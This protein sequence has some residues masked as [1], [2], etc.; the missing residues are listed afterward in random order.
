MVLYLEIKKIS[1]V[2]QIFENIKE[3][4]QSNVYKPGDKLPSEIVLAE[5]YGVSRVSVRTAIQRLAM[6]GMIDIRV[7]EGSFV[8]EFNFRDLTN[9]I[10][11]I[12]A[13]NSMLEFLFE[14]RSNIEIHCVKLAISRAADYELKQLI[15]IARDMFEKAKN[16]D[17]SGY[18]ERNYDYHYLLCTLSKNRL[19]EFVYS[20]IKDLFLLGIKTNLE[21]GDSLGYNALNTSAKNHIY[22][23]E[24]IISRKSDEACSYLDSIINFYIY[25]NSKQEKADSNK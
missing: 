15:V 8:K 22:L 9:Q 21:T 19:Y 6:L 10:S 20:S 4:I 13:N 24:L 5:M 1:I 7:G 25:A 2:D 17:L 3:D 11:E 14:F 16:N 23:S 18:I 12:I